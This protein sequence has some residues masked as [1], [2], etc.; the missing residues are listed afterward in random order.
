ME[1]LHDLTA[2]YALDALDPD[3]ERAYEEHLRRCPRCQE[4]LAAFA[5]TAAALAHGV[6]APPPPPALRERILD[7]VAAERRTV[8][9]LASRRPLYA[10]VAAAAAAAV[11][12]IAVGVW[13]ASLSSE[14]SREGYAR[15]RNS[16]SPVGTS[17]PPSGSSV[18]ATVAPGGTGS[19]SR[20]TS[21]SSPPPKRP[22][23]FG[24]S[25]S[26]T[27]IS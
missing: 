5:E 18:T 8:V 1:Q 11:A 16:G 6:D 15:A 13:A 27:Q 2:A 12:A 9:P 17:T 24:R 4:E 23:G 14:L 26:I 22:A 10:A 19:S 25:P 20:T 7:Q 21:T 3:E